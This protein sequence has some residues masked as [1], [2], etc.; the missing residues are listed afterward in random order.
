MVRVFDVRTNCFVCGVRA[1]Q[2]QGPISAMTPVHTSYGESISVLAY[3]GL[4]RQLEIR[5]SDES[6]FSS[7]TPS[8]QVRAHSLGYTSAMISHLTHPILVSASLHPVIKVWST[9]GENVRIQL[10]R[11]NPFA[12]SVL[13]ISSIRPYK[14][15]RENCQQA[16]TSLAFHPSNWKRFAAGGK[17]RICG[18][19]DLTTK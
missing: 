1:F 15:N 13:Q 16:V 8:F 11:K 6:V 3:G 2:T 18:L 17:G 7:L 9:D 14:K 5:Q 12:E 4:M 19:Y 10:L